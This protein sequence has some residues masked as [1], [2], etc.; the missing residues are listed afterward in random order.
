M[1]SKA[2]SSQPS[3]TSTT[4]AL[5][6]PNKGRKRLYTFCGVIAAIVIASALFVPQALGSTIELGLNYSVGEKMLYTT[7]N[8]VTNQMS[9]TTIDVQTNPISETYN[10]T[11]SYEILGFD[12]ENYTIKLTI[13]SEINGKTISIPLTT[14]NTR[15]STYYNNLLPSGSPAFFLNVTGNPALEA[16]LAKTQVNLGDVWQ[17]PVSTGNASLG[18]TGEIT[19]KFAGIQEI[20]VPAGTYKVFVVELSSNNLTMHI[21]PDNGVISG[22]ILDNSILQL[23][24][25][26]Y[27]EYGTCRLIKSELTQETTMQ[28]T[29]ISGASIIYSEKILV[30]HTKP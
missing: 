14:N 3:N 15:K 6:I 23:T 20:T 28:A 13:T 22:S 30:E 27:L 29:G 26:T 18:L 17:F 4:S 8:T 12:G 21:S 25:K 11:G 24:G 2:D 7:T 19:L 10:S 5:P 1:F 9:N 16:Y